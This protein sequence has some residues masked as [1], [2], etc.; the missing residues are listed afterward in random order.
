MPPCVAFSSVGYELAQQILCR[1]AAKSECSA[2][3]GMAEIVESRRQIKIANESTGSRPD[4]VRKSDPVVTGIRF[5]DERK[6]Y[7]V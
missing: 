5:V 7:R 2:S 3:F 6:C 1:E 4:E